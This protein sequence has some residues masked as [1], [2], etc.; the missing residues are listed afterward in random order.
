MVL[1]SGGNGARRAPYAHTD[2]P[3]V[4]A[5][6][7]G[8]QSR[9]DHHTGGAAEPDPG[10]VLAPLL[11]RVPIRQ[12]R[13]CQAGKRAHRESPSRRVRGFDPAGVREG[14]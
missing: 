10:P 12:E 8:R 5:A 6:L 14:I 9:A 13:R 11:A 4:A 3:V 2:I 1:Q 7:A